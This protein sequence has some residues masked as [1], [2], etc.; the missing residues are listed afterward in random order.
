[1]T[2]TDA[3]TLAD[4][5]RT[6]LGL[7]THNDA[8]EASLR[9]AA[10]DD[11]ALL[12]LATR[13]DD[14]V[15]GGAAG[16]ANGLHAATERR[17]PHPLLAWC[18]GAGG[19]A[20]PLSLLLLAHAAG[21]D[22][23]V[24]ASDVAVPACDDARLT[25]L[26]AR[27]VATLPAVLRAWVSPLSRA[28]TSGPGT[29]AAPHGVGHAVDP[30]LLRHLRVARG[31]LR[32]HS[33]TPAGP[34]DLVVC[35][36]VL[37]HYRPDVALPML[38]R[39]TDAMADHGVLVLSVVDALAV[40]LSIDDDG[41]GVVVL[42]RRRSPAPRPMTT[43]PGPLA[44]CALLDEDAA[45]KD[46][47]AQL[48]ALGPEVAGSSVAAAAALL[49]EGRIHDARLLVDD[50]D[51]DDADLMRALCDCR[52]GRL[53]EARAHL[54]ALRLRMPSSW[55]TTWLLAEVVARTGRATESRALLSA[56]LGLLQGAGSPAGELVALLPE[57]HPQHVIQSGREALE[58]HRGLWH[59]P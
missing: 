32:S 25:V 23:D 3:P 34:F 1:M 57:L 43:P 44:L 14:V 13:G 17:G 28:P 38:A 37:H 31:D 49:A 29:P 35:R 15:L 59:R 18:A 56:T 42:D 10:V 20:E 51:G 41:A 26:A 53:V 16:L 7:R 11:S 6:R 22:V 30:R 21:V 36:E 58:G 19:L 12:H 40:G 45:V 46:R 2:S 47:A 8:I 39:L 4:R 50:D 27:R 52:L 55:V 9:D 54:E 48:K 5:V 24:V 33:H